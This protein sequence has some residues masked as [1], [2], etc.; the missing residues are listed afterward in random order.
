MEFSQVLS[1]VCTGGEIVEKVT[2]ASIRAF[3]FCVAF[4]TTALVGMTGPLTFTKYGGRCLATLIPGDG[5]GNEATDCVK[6]VF[7]H[8]KVPVDFDEVHLSGHD[9]D[10]C[11]SKSFKMA[12]ES[13]RRT[14]VGLKGIFLPFWLASIVLY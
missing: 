4:D 2:M 10:D 7:D 9:A 5:I 11:S 6:R 13:L 3:L 1:C 8:M 14:K 12:L